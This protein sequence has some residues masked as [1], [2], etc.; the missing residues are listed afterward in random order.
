[1]ASI[2]GCGSKGALAFARGLAALG[3]LNPVEKCHVHLWKAR[4]KARLTWDVSETL[5]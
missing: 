1:M 4:I 3:G 5:T 2:E